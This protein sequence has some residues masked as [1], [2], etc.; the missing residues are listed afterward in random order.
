MNY[1]LTLEDDDTNTLIWYI[2]VV[3][4]VH[5]GMKSDTRAVFT[6]GKMSDY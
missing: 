2:N 5:D 6:M 3:F 1:V 4:A